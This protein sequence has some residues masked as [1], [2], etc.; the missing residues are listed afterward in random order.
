[1]AYLIKEELKMEIDIEIAPDDADKRNYNVEFEKVKKIIGWNPKYSV[2]DGVNEIYQ[3]LRK[4]KVDTSVKT[5]TVNWYRSIIEAHSLI[6][7]IKLNE[8][9]I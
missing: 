1:L 2:E 9:I 8:R 5:I 6:E 3:S 4:G 7:S